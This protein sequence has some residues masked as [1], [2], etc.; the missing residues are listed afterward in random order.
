MSKDIETKGMMSAEECMEKQLEFQVAGVETMG[1]ELGEMMESLS[2]EMS[3]RLG[4]A[5]QDLSSEVNKTLIAACFDVYA[6]MRAVTSTGKLELDDMTILNTQ[7]L[8]VAE[9]KAKRA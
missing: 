2:E 1:Y 9:G 8:I 3:K 5:L 6:Q 4:S 7:A